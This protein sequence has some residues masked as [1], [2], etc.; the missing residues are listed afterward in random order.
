[1]SDNNETK[2]MLERKFQ[3]LYDKAKRIQLSI[4]YCPALDMSAC[5]ETEAEAKSSFTET[6]R[7]SLAYMLDKKTLKKDLND[8][9]WE[10]KS[11]KDGVR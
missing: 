5:G 6:L 11:L 7:M 1:M 9:G 8:H 4:V 3:Y 10:I 2:E